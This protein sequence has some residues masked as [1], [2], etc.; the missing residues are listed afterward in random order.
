MKVNYHTHCN[1]CRHADGTAEEY[2]LSATHS[3]LDVL[4]F[5]DHGPFPDTDF[6]RLRMPYEELPAYLN[7]LKELKEKYGS[8]I[9]LYSG[10]EIEYMK[11][12]EPYY[13]ALL[14]EMGLDYL[15]LGQHFFKNGS[16]GLT[17][18]YSL[19]SSEE[20]MEYARSACEGMRSGFFQILAHPDLYMFN[21]F[22]WDQN[23][24]KAC[25]LLIDAAISTGT[26]L[27]YNANG[28]R[29]GIHVFPDGARYYYPDRRFWEIAAR[30]A[31][32]IRVIV[33]SDCHNPSQV[34]DEAMNRAYHDL[35]KL[36][37]APIFGFLPR[38]AF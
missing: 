37:I 1:R 26:I 25:E 8:Q 11:E 2:V 6:K 14:N 16:G 36:G 31:S 35:E 15:I 19:K 20:A 21:A 27:E 22:P 9:T 30:H 10:L 33:G 34:W 12:F 32:E 4:G 38:Q 18:L 3:G 23:C 13:R 28:Y 5:S 7:D 29:R 24:E 17:D